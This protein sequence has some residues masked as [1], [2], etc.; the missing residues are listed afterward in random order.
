MSIF[1]PRLIAVDMDG[2]ILNSSSELSTRTKNALRSAIACGV[3][4]V[5]ATGR[6]YPSALPVI[7]EIGINAPCIFY[8]G[9][10]VR[11]PVSGEILLEKGL[12]KELTAEVVSFYREEGWYI[13]IYSDDRL[14]VKDSYDPRSRFYE[15]ISKIRPV[16][17]GEGFWDFNV[18]STKLLGIALDEI[19]MAQMA[20]KTKLRFEGRVYLATSW[21]AFVEI[22]HPEV[23]KAKGLAIVAEKLGIDPKDVLAIGD[24]VNDKE[25]IRWAGFGVAMGNAPDTV[26]AAADETTSDNDSDGAAVIIERYLCRGDKK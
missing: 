17:L 9:A 19:T 6:M 18:D 24:G 23:N 15:A 11:E 14:Y 16:S 5:V 7:K 10:V 1:K 4:V 25:M 12:G 22:T 2:T 26:K 8:N 21:G 13:Q 20:E 3:P